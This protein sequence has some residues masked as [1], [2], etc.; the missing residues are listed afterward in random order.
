MK[1]S[2]SISLLKSLSSTAVGFAISLAAQY[3]VLPYLLGVPV[4][5]AANLSFAAIMTVISIVRGYVIDRIFEMLGWR[6]RTSPF[7]NAALHE[8]QRQIKAEGW[9][10]E[11]D[12]EHATGELELAGAAYALGERIIRC[13]RWQDGETVEV[14]GQLIFPWDIGWWKPRDYRRNLV[15]SAAL[16][17]AAGEKCDRARKIKRRG[18]APAKRII[19]SGASS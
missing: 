5:I 16:I 13:E 11:H 15:R 8:R 7:V 9:T 17:I 3:A 1:Q 4:P 18:I 14:T 6:V 2:R 12:D 10:I 19:E